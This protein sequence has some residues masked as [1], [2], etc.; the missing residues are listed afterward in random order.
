[1]SYVGAL[2][3][4]LY[5][6][7]EHGLALWDALWAAGQ[8]HGVVAAGRSGFSGLRLEKGYRLWGTDMT[9]EHDP[10]E[11]GLGFALRLDKGDFV[12][13]TALEDK[14]DEISRRL[15]CLVL[16]HPGAVVM[17]K[18]PVLVD[19]TPR[20]YVTSAAYGYTIGRAI[21]SAWLPSTEIGTE[22]EIEYFGRR[23]A[24]TVSAEPLVDPAM[25]RIR[26]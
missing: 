1:V 12:G 15:T 11:A 7:A 3:W 2:G 22:V 20:G 18:E 14:Q 13:R 17:G 24:A 19:G 5:T 8:E 26:C 23:L 25:S 9:A 6:P 21:A 16:D 4:E 10:Y